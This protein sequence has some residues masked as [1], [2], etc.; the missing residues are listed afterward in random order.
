VI[1]GRTVDGLRDAAGAA[2]D[3]AARGARHAVV[4]AGSQGAVLAGAAGS[5]S[6]PGFRVRS[7]DS[8][9]AGDAF[10]AALGVTL[11]AGLPPAAALRAACAAGA[12]A[13]TRRGAQIALP[14]PAEILAATGQNWPA[15][16][17]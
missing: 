15:V 7:I 11:A 9:G 8:V 3:L 4:T 16:L 6:V 1:L 2:A 12:T 5:E 14:R 17:S 13:T 10:V